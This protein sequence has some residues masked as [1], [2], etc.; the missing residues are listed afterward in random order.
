MKCLAYRCLPAALP[1]KGAHQGAEMLE[2]QVPTS[3]PCKEIGLRS[4][5]PDCFLCWVQHEAWARESVLCV[6]LTLIQLLWS[7]RFLSSSMSYVYVS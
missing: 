6:N 5:G 4:E 3:M 7:S 2:M 1:V